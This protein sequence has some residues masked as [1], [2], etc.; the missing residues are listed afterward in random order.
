MGPETVSR[1][2]AHPKFVEMVGKRRRAIA[3]LVTLSMGAYVAFL[4]VL[5]LAPAALAWPLSD[6]S[7][8]TIGLAASFALILWAL[9][10]T[11]LYV[12]R[13]NREFDRLNADIL[14]DLGL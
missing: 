1:F 11:G 12:R 5:V 2:H 6:G 3:A 4:L 8:L 7:N 9:V 13:A 10:I 14:A